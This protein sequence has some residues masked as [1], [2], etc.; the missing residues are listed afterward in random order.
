M[1]LQRLEH[2][3][4]GEQLRQARRVIAQPLVDVTLRAETIGHPGL[5][6]RLALIGGV[7]QGISPFAERVSALHFGVAERPS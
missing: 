4:S 7:G 1:K 3:L 6:R 5:V 2:P